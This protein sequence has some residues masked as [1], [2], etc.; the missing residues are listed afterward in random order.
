MR[1]GCPARPRL[2]DGLAEAIGR[3]SLDL[4]VTDETPPPGPALT[5]SLTFDHPAAGQRRR[6]RCLTAPCTREMKNAGTAK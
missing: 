5:A 2:T 3:A 4:L 1:K 6:E